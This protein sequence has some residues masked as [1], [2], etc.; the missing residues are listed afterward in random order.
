MVTVTIVWKG[1][2]FPTVKENV[3]IEEGLTILTIWESETEYSRVM[4]HAIDYYDVEV[5]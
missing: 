5:E 2:K 4:L 3:E 1:D